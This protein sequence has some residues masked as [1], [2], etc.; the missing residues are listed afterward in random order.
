VTYSCGDYKHSLE[1]LYVF[2]LEHVVQRRRL[3]LGGVDLGRQILRKAAGPL[4]LCGAVSGPFALAR[5]TTVV[6]NSGLEVHGLFDDAEYHLADFFANVRFFV[7]VLYML[8]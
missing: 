6:V 1:V 5:L 4:L 3:A 8:M 7:V 2:C